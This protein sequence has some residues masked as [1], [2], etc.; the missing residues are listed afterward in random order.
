MVNVVLPGVV[1]D[2]TTFT[3]CAPELPNPASALSVLEEADTTAVP[4]YPPAEV[5]VMVEVPLFPGDGDE[6]VTFVAIT[7][8]LGLVTVTGAVPE[9]VP[10]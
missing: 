1:G 6:M 9:E 8:I 4:E 10:L 3:D 2:I 5:R 7:V